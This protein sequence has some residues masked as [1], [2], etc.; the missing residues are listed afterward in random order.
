MILQYIVIDIKRLKE[1]SIFSHNV[2]IVQFHLKSVPFLMLMYFV[3]INSPSAPCDRL[4]QHTRVHSLVSVCGATGTLDRQNT[5]N[6]MDKRHLFLFPAP[7][8]VHPFSSLMSPLLRL[9]PQ[10]YPLKL[11]LLAHCP[12]PWMR[13]PSNA[14]RSSGGERGAGEVRGLWGGLSTVVRARTS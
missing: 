3:Y 7:L 1:L 6:V 4:H 9:P 14:V 10:P 8:H 12:Q 5:Q 13:R 2:I 11:Q